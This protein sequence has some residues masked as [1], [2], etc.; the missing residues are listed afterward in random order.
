MLIR[1]ETSSDYIGITRVN[2]EAFGQPKESRLIANLRKN[3]K[4][5]TD[6]SLVAEKD[7]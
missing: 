4:F 2:D 5:V 1:S 6:L 7:G 3:P